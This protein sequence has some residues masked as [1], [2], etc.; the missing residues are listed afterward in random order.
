MA[1][2]NNTMRRRHQNDTHYSAGQQLSKCPME[3]PTMP[4]G[5][6]TEY[7]GGYSPAEKLLFF[8]TRIK[9]RAAEAAQLAEKIEQWWANYYFQN[10]IRM[11]RGEEPNLPTREKLQKTL[12]PLKELLELLSISLELF[13]EKA[14]AMVDYICGEEKSTSTNLAEQV[15]KLLKDRL[16]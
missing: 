5:Y 15:D 10:R 16:R 13:D 12:D 3:V 14:K 6:H 1:S 11:V 4:N 9:E 8:F 2:T 7:S